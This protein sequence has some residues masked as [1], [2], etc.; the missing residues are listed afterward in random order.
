MA[1]HSDTKKNSSHPAASLKASPHQQ[2]SLRAMIFLT[3]L[4]H[5]NIHSPADSLVKRRYEQ[6][7]TKG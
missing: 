5:S 1:T 2:S 4:D 7:L 3:T 6:G